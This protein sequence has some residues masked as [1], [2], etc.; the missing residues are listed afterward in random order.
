M[1]QGPGAGP[2]QRPGRPPDQRHR[3]VR[4][5]PAARDPG[6]LDRR[7]HARRPPQVPGLAVGIRA[8]RKQLPVGPAGL[9]QDRADG[10]A[11]QRRLGLGIRDRGRRAAGPQARQGAGQP[12]LRQGLGAGDPAAVREHRGQAHHFALLHA[13]RP[14]HP[15]HRHRAR[16]RG[17]RHRRRR[18]VPPA[19]RSR[20]ATPPVEPADHQRGEVQRRPGKRRTAGQD[21]RIRRQGRLPAAA[22]VEP[23]GR[24]AGAEGLGPRPGQ[25]RRQGWRPGAAHE[26]HADRS[27]AQQ[28]K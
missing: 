1:P 13:Q 18:P 3:R 22:G 24:Q 6:G 7:P 15:G 5:L 12:H 14:F 28:E 25:G 17:G 19:A 21:L 9:D 20:P 8:W 11:G 16:L 26:D 10:G 27:R 2:A 23:A 4:R